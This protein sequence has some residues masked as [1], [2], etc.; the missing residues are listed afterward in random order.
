MEPT[1]ITVFTTVAVTVGMPL[2]VIDRL[3]NVTGD[4]NQDILTH[5]VTNVCKC[6]L[7]ALGTK[8]DFEIVKM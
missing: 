3:D 2:H 6:S 4:V 1:V 5:C 8:S 7:P